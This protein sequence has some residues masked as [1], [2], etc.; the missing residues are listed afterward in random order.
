LAEQKREIETRPDNP[1]ASEPT[2]AAGGLQSV[3]RFFGRLRS[4]T[5]GHWFRSVLV[6]AAILVLIAATMAVWAYLASVALRSGEPSIDVALRALD[7]GHFEEARTLVGRMLKSGRLRRNKYGGPLFVLGAVKTHDA[8]EQ[9]GPDQRRIEYLVASRY[10]KEANTYGLPAGRELDGLFL[11]GK[12]FVESGQFTEGIS[13][14]NELLT[15]NAPGDHP[16]AWESHR[17]LS[18]TYLLMPQ[19]NPEKALKHTQKLLEKPDL[20][21]EQRAGAQL[22][23]AECLTRLGRFGEARQAAAAVPADSSRQAEVALMRGKIDLEEINAALQRVAPQNRQSILEQSKT[24]VADA[25][26]YLQ[27][28][29]S[30]DDQKGQVAR[31][32]SY[33]I[34]RGLQFQG[35]ADE[36]AKQFARTRQL[37]GDTLEGLAAALAE[38]DL[39]RQNG[40]FQ[41][42]LFGYRRVLESFPGAAAY[43]SVILPMPQLR[44]RLMT[45]LKDFV[46]RKRFAEALSLIEH[47]TPLFSRTEQLE[48]RGDTL[49]R[50]GKDLI[51]QATGFDQA[52]ARDRAAGRRHLRSAGLAFEQLAEL[53]YATRQYSGDLWRGADNY[54]HGHSYSST[55]RLLN[56]YLANE[57]EL[58]NPDALLRLGQAHL[59]L[60]QTSQS[61]MAFEECIEFHPL[62]SSTFQARIDCAKAH[63]NDGKTDR[64]E[65]LLRDNLAATS[66][67]PTSREW[68]DSQ[69]ELGMLLHEMGRYEDAIGTL[70]EAIMRYPHDPQRLLSQYI[71]GESYRRWAQELLDKAPKI[72]T[73]GER[74]KNQELCTERLNQALAHFEEVHR[75]ITLKTH[76]IHSDPLMA[77]MLRNCYMLEGAVL[78]ELGNLLGDKNRYKDAIEAYSNVASLYPDEPFVLETFVQIANCWRRLKLD[79][80]ARGSIQQA[81]IALDRLPRDA[82][83]VSATALNR[84]EWQLL[85][86]NMSTW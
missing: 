79:D 41:E 21:A 45:A 56:E 50:W 20:S 39:L 60:G 49:E 78:F 3:L 82:D 51:E 10:L 7:E 34:G 4:W 37:Y 43:R 30:L 48:L 61:I 11:L 17:M 65:Q 47:F 86:A 59:A 18:N 58:R 6:A 83:F 84:D 71:I 74:K 46:N 38:A 57:P 44:E 67:R 2:V 15:S 76:D 31:Q 5:A 13:T 85:L 64:S 81:Q 66:L 27:E 70:E 72:R 77:S 24:K 75:T 9:L 23:L 69:F 68:K 28:A 16:L 55:V 62:S 35:H 36:A 22:Q 29:R 26:R 52:A 19:S 42:S 80:K 25:L 40:N 14:L 33:H 73:D 32:V 12:S 1:A 54:F 63:W 8:E 53:R